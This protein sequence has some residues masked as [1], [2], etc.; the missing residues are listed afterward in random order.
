MA[1]DRETLK[2]A[3]IGALQ[4]N[5]DITA[6]ETAVKEAARRY[7]TWRKTAADTNAGDNTAEFVV[8]TV[9]RNSRVVRVS[10]TA[11]ANVAVQTNDTI[12]LTAKVHTAADP[13]N[14][15]IVAN[16]IGTSA[17]F[18]A[19]TRWVPKDITL[20]P[21]NAQM[22]TNSVVTFSITKANSGTALAAGV[23]TV[24]IEEGD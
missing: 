4:G 5:K 19:L 12:L 14:G 10:Y 13:A 21:A 22:L 18:G 2:K 17:G 1:T 20:V 16:A 9:H 15:L 6:P 24:D 7:I 3:Q 23:L 11:D 8:G